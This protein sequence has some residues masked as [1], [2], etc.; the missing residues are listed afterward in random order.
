IGPDAAHRARRLDDVLARDDFSR[1]TDLHRAK[2]KM[3]GMS[4]SR[5]L[6]VPEA[7]WNSGGSRSGCRQNRSARTDAFGGRCET[8]DPVLRTVGPR[9]TKDS[10]LRTVFPVF[11]VRGCPFSERFPELL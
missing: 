8:K 9:E 5:R 6:S 2:T 1:A 11:M 7:R 3:P 10:L 4:A